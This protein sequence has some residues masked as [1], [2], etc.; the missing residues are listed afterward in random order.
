MYVLR[1]EGLAP[2]V[3]TVGGSE[4]KQIPLLVP[5][6]VDHP[7]QIM[8][9]DIMELPLTTKGNKYPIVLQYL[10]SMAFPTPDQKALRIAQLFIEKL[11]PLFGIPE[12][13]LSDR[14]TNLLS[15]LMQDVCKLLGTR[16]LNTK[17][18]FLIVMI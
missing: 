14:G 6:P 11:V 13:L 17:P 2:S 12:A 9:V 7:F 5:I 16:K 15:I 10:L 18:T 4:Q 8:G 1:L 3:T